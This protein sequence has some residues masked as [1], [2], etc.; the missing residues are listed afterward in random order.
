[1]KNKTKTISPHP[2]SFTGSASLRILLSSLLC[3]AGG[4][5]N[6]GCSK[7]T[8]CHLCHCLLL[9]L[10]PCFSIR[11][12]PQQTVLHELLERLSHGQQLFKNCFSMGF[13]P[14]G[15]VVQKKTA[16]VWVLHRPHLPENLPLHRLFSTGYCQ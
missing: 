11:S 10:F 2:P 8:E 12:L 14:W 3:S 16:P 15:S 4:V 1:M 9:T 13:S 5:G 7:T 6:R